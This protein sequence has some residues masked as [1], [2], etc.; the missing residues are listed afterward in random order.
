M[1]IQ[2]S[3]GIVGTAMLAS[4]Q[5]SPGEP[6]IQGHSGLF[7]FPSGCDAHREFGDLCGAL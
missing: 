6:L 1:L 2:T 3:D 4:S 7:F 5:R